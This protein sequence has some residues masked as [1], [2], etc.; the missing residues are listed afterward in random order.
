M[1]TKV[2]RLS[3]PIVHAARLRALFGTAVLL[4]SS[5]ALSGCLTTDG[6]NDEDDADTSGADVSQPQPDA[7]NDVSNDIDPQPDTDPR[8]TDTPDPDT[9]IPDTSIPDA[10]PDT[11]PDA[12][13]TTPDVPSGT[14]STNVTFSGGRDL[15][16]G[17]WFPMT[18]NGVKPYSFA[19]NSLSY[20]NATDAPIQITNVEILPI[21]ETQS[22]E[23]THRQTGTENSPLYEFEPFTL[24][25]G[26]SITVHAKFFPV[27]TG[28]IQAH[29]RVSFDDGLYSQVILQGRGRDAAFITPSF[30]ILSETT[31]GHANTSSDLLAGTMVADDDGNVYVSANVTNWVDTFNHDIVV[32]RFNPDG[33]VAWARQWNEEYTQEQPDSGQN[34]QT[35]GVAR[36]MAMGADGFLYVVGRRS[37]AQT[38]NTWDALVLKI[39]PADGALVWAQAVGENSGAGSTEG[40][41]I[42]A[43]LE[44]RL[45]ITGITGSDDRNSDVLLLALSKNDGSILYNHNI[46]FDGPDRGYTL[47]VAPDGTGYLGGWMSAPAGLLIRVEDLDTDSP[48]VDWTRIIGLPRGSLVQDIDV[49]ADGN[50]YVSFDIRGTDTYLQMSRVDSDGT[51]AWNAIHNQRSRGDIHTTSVI[52][53]VDGTVWA[54]GRFGHDGFD[55]TNGDGFLLRMDAASGDYGGMDLY[56]TG[57]TAERVAGHRVKGFAFANDT[58]H[59]MAE[60]YTGARNLEHYWGFWYG[61]P[62]NNLREP[63]GDGSAN[64]SLE[65]PL[66]I[67][68]PTVDVVMGTRPTGTSVSFDGSATQWRAVPEAVTA[69]PARIR[70]GNGGHGTAFVTRI[71]VTD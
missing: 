66:A 38:N 23:W 58:L 26:Q 11:T 4:A 18:T 3:P 8:D 30:D 28:L 67:E 32:A 24:E 33:S 41:A 51:A 63:F 60:S 71:R 16:D 64:H 42:D 54:G 53:Y 13:D 47:A 68:P 31:W 6:D 1:M 19:T 56:Y 2:V 69:A 49:D 57:T 44:D 15:V 25:A 35:G 27:R 34:G 9:A 65:N 7:G 40:Y 43:T 45:I 5:V 50:A 70:T 48:T 52:R 21:G 12:T 39:N 36:S 29:L 46:G 22:M 10:D 37:T 62:N 20:R 17:V 14:L 61:S 55:Y 59:V